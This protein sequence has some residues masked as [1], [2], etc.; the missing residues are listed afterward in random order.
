MNNEPNNSHHLA[1]W[2]RRQLGRMLDS[3][4]AANFDPHVV[5][6][7]HKAATKEQII[8][9]HLRLTKE[10]HPD[11]H[12]GDPLAVE[13]LK[14]I[15]VARDSLI[16]QQ[17]CFQ[18]EHSTYENANPYQNNYQHQYHHYNQQQTSTQNP[19][20][21]Q[22][23]HRQWRTPSNN[24]DISY[25]SRSE[26][27]PTQQIFNRF[28]IGV[29]IVASIILAILFFQ[30][31]DGTEEAD[32]TDNS[33]SRSSIIS[34]T[35]TIP[36][37]TSP[38]AEPPEAQANSESAND[39]FDE[40]RSFAL[41]RINQI[42]RDAGLGEVSLLHLPSTQKHAEDMK[43]NCFTSPWGS[44]GM[45]PY[46]RY[47]LAG[48]YQHTTEVNHGPN[49]C[50]TF[51]FQYERES[52][53]DQIDDAIATA[54]ELDTSDSLNVDVLD[55]NARKLAIGL[56]Y[57]EP[58][59]WTVMTFVADYIEYDIPPFIHNQTLQF[60]ATAKH[61]VDL[62][63]DGTTV[64][65]FYDEPIYSL[66]RGQLHQTSCYWHG[67]FVAFIRKP[68]EPG[69][70]YQDETIAFPSERCVDPYEIPVDTPPID[71]PDFSPTPTV[72]D[73][74]EEGVLLVADS[75]ETTNDQLRLKVDLSIL[76]SLF[77]DGIYT[78]AIYTDID[79]EP[80][81]ISEYSIFIPPP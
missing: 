58:A 15:N 53:E 45:K 26:A 78:I 72:V 67:D 18:P 63:N 49:Y 69:W 1:D 31:L 33:D 3:W 37:R 40:L 55:P 30:W 32:L 60:T 39:D 14:Q 68:L 13:L 12:F 59:L 38:T 4:R 41:S 48:G 6:G 8:A 46:M 42:R 10:F 20:D 16:Q 24:R 23:Q 81:S 43:E 76:L 64:A 27:S 2:Q 9:A 57:R 77:G 74:I 19:D 11:L 66:R 54:L 65:I 62:T 29:A 50:P 36:V 80:T 7:V 25:T 34:Q 28:L 61:G 71:S 79:G 56:A 44:D 75:W 47:S 70:E 22:Q 17:S 52:I 35:T 5:L 73:I 51:G 21:Q